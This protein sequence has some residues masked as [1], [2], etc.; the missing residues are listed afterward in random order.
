MPKYTIK[1]IFLFS[2]SV[3]NC[4]WSE[5]EIKG[6]SLLYGKID[7]IRHDDRRM[8]VGDTADRVNPAV[9]HLADDAFART[10]IETSGKCI[11]VYGKE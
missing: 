5:K 6:G 4:V 9:W 10:A 8:G 2:E 11:K 3:R 1:F 7:R